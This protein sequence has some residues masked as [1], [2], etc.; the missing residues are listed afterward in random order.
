MVNLSFKED[1]IKHIFQLLAGK[2]PYVHKHHL[3]MFLIDLLASTYNMEK[4]GELIWKGLQ[5]YA[6]LTSGKLTFTLLY[7]YYELK[8]NLMI[9]LFPEIVKKNLN[10]HA[11]FIDIVQDLLKKSIIQSSDHED[12]FSILSINS[13]TTNAFLVLSNAVIY[14]HPALLYEILRDLAMNNVFRLSKI[15]SGQPSFL[16]IRMD[17]LRIE[18]G[19]NDMKIAEMKE[20]C[21]DHVDHL[22]NPYM[23][24]TSLVDVG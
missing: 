13:E 2:K 3:F 10:N 21:C 1:N 12:A 24:V 14:D 6:K 16:N 19:I 20:F 4:G 15:I 7:Q 11:L 17:Q 5:D 18:L 22:I 9:F 8:F 23:T